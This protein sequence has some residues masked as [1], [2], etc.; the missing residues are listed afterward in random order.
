MK[1]LKRRLLASALAAAVLAGSAACG[2]GEGTGTS[3]DG[4][5]TLWTHNAGNPEELAVVEQIVADWNAAHPEKKI[6]VQAFPQAAYNE[7]VVAAATAKKLPCILDTDAPTV[8]NWAYAGYLVPLEI[9]ADL[10]AKQLPSTVGT[11]QGKTYSVGYYEAALGLFARKS[12]LNAAGVRIPTL[13]QP[14][15][16]TEFDRALR[17]IKSSG[18]YPITF[19]LGTGDTTTEWWT[20]A[21]SPFLQSFGGD[22]I[23]R[24]TYKTSSGVLN[25]DKALAWARWLQG[26]VKQGYSPQ[27]SS[28]DAFADFVNG[29][30]AMVWSGIWNSGSLSKVEDG[31]VLPPPDFGN[32]PKIGGGSWQWAVSSSCADKATAMEYLRSSL[33]AKSIAA[34]AEKQNVIPATEE[35]AALAPGWQPGGE[36]RFF[37]EESRKLAM[38][39]PPTPGYPYL[40]T[41]FAKATQDIIAGGDPK[42]IL[43]RAANEIDRDLKSNNY[44]GF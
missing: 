34:F 7:A 38:V 28:Q 6:T 18:K 8:P 23:D 37:L 32:G 12:A 39:R 29:K 27:R 44:Y 9:P 17:A 10:L 13:E 16:A 35:A 24:D 40:T 14:W 21:Y 11:Y 41:T 25:G 26:L 36:K 20:Y 30:S 22:L 19:D 3:A 5:L 15:T 31:V 33:T 1:P 43:D 4:G 2:S 42:Q